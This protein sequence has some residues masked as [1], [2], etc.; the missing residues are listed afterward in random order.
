MVLNVLSQF[1]LSPPCLSCLLK[2]RFFS[3]VKLPPVPLSL[4]GHLFIPA[5][6]REFTQTHTCIHTKLSQTCLK[7]FVNLCDIIIDY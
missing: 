3:P 7:H 4:C 5:L 6:F 1:C 2:M